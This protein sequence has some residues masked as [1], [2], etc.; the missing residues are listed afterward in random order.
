VAAK[1]FYVSP[2]GSDS[3]NGLSPSVNFW[4]KT[5]PFKTLTRARN[6]IRQ[7]KA[8]GKFN[9]AITVHVGKGTY[10]LQSALELDDRD[11]G[12]PDQ[13]ILWVGE[14]GTSVITGG[15]PINNCQPYSAADTLQIFSCPLKADTVVNIAREN[16]NR[17]QGNA[18]EFEVFVNENRMHL[19]RWPD[20]S[21]AHIRLPLND[22]TRF[23]VFEQMPKLL[24]DLSDAQ[25]HIFPGNDIYDHYTG[26]SKIDFINNLIALSSETTYKL[27][28][29]RRFYLENVEEA[30][31]STEE[32]F[33]DKA[34]NRILL[35]PPTNAIPNNI[36]ISAAKNLI[37]INASHH[38]GFHNL[39]LRH[40]TG[41]AIRINHSDKVTLENLE[42]SNNGDKAISALENTNI[43]ISNN[44]IH[45]TGTGGIIISGGDRPT[46]KASGNVVNNN[47]IHDY[48]VG[49]FNYAQAIETSGVASVISHNLI[50]NG[51]GK[52]ILI[53]GNDHIIEKNEI[54]NI[55]NQT[56]DCGA[57]YS[58][59]DWT[60][61]G[62]IVRYNYLHDFS[63]YQLKL[64]DI[65][66]N[67]IQYAPEG[68]RGIYLDDAVSGFNVFGNI[69]VNAGTISLQLGGGRDN[70]IENNVFKTSY[71]AIYS[72]RRYG[73]YN[74]DNNRDSLKTMP[75]TSALW[76]HKYPELG[77]PMAHDT[78]PEGNSIQ[79]NIIISTNNLGFSLLYM[80]PSQGN[81]IGNN[82]VWHDSSNIRVF[83]E[84]V[85]T[86]IGKDRALWSNWID[87]GIETK[88]L[89]EDPCL[90][91]SGS[92]VRID[93]TNSP[94]TKIGFQLTPSDIGLVQ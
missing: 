92:I 16:N 8:A 87:Q 52:A 88:S 54:S 67:I 74:W 80:L 41:A 76:S 24:G 68:A 33:Y 65:E 29:G 5:G 45:D 30:L 83:Y 31:N 75:I 69:M 51:N 58:G 48:D 44:H 72:D 37:T 61:R 66:K 43:S 27:A 78:W 14:K 64:L 39:A 10:R 23:S 34:N 1:D 70:R 57:I 12:S 94:A 56:G 18:P 63:G 11:S 19:A 84:V 21:W 53:H 32:W 77:I 28:S 73:S 47:Y 82:I 86:M 22:K 6:A 38:I 49:L 4:T 2:S 15:I 13:E 9:E 25:V 85:G 89:N 79:R 35:I 71:F 46:L 59:R 26:V 81:S 60:Y 90:N 7:L 62:N 50:K 42:I 3:L 36:L 17:F 55:C 91:I 93:C 20:N 40:S